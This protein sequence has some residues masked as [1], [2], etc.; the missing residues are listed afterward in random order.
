MSSVHGSLIIALKL[1]D[2][3]SRILKGETL[4]PESPEVLIV[5]PDARSHFINFG[6][7]QKRSLWLND[8]ALI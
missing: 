4:E 7:R 8:G 2:G 5:E 6:P 3:Y 1:P